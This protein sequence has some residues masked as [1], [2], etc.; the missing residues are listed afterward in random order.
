MKLA[1]IEEKIRTLEANKIYIEKE[2]K[3]IIE[4]LNLLGI[5]DIE[6]AIKEFESQK[7]S[8]EDLEKEIMNIEKEIKE[9]EDKI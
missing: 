6:T 8:I 7:N 1:E 5:T 2:I 4:K 9:F 3:S